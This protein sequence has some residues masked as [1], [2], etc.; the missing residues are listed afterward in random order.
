ML[1]TAMWLALAIGVL[2]GIWRFMVTPAV[3]RERERRK[4]REPGA[5]LNFTA[6]MAA[7]LAAFVFGRSQQ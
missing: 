3:E 6:V 4:I 7:V 1:Q 5:A 2:R